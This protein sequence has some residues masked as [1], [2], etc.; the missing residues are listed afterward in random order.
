MQTVAD[1]TRQKV[2]GDVDE[3]GGVFVRK[4]AGRIDNSR[5]GGTVHAHV[6][7]IPLTHSHTATTTTTR[8]KPIII[9][10]LVHLIIS[11]H[12]NWS[13]DPRYHRTFVAFITSSSHFFSYK[14]STDANT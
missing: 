2:G 7:S 10:A 8:S 11:H 1:D 9:I 12:R 5:G 3:P 14:A 6:H 4:P 13:K